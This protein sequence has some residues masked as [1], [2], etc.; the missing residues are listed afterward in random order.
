MTCALREAVS[1]A[2]CKHVCHA[3]NAEQASHLSSEY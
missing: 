2:M 3:G 1:K